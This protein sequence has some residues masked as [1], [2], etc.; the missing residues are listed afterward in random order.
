MSTRIVEANTHYDLTKSVVIDLQRMLCE[1]AIEKERY[2]T[3]HSRQQTEIAFL[4]GNDELREEAKVTLTRQ[5]LKLSATVRAVQVTD[6]TM[7]IVAGTLLQIA[8]QGLVTRYGQKIEDCPIE[9]RITSG[10][11]IREIIWFGRNQAMH[12][13]DSKPG[14]W[15]SLFKT[16]DQHHPGKFTPEPVSRSMAIIDLL[17]WMSFEQYEADMENL[18]F[19]TPL[20]NV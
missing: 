3:T 15:T 19:F 17:G 6:Q 8:R 14:S 1:Q 9:G 4:E 7:T 20:E 5:R 13:D 18:G 11:H 12:F 16:L 2:V 10:A